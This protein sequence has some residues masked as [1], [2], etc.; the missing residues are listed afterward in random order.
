[1]KR[2][3]R[4][5]LVALMALPVVAWAQAPTAATPS[6][7]HS[8]L[9]VQRL[10]E[11][12][13]AALVL[14]GK[15]W[16]FLK[17]HHPAVTAGQRP[18]DD[19][20]LA[21]LPA[22]L[23]ARKPRD[24]Q[25]LLTQWIDALGPVE[26]CQ[27]C[28]GEGW[29]A[30]SV[31]SQPRTRWIADRRLL[32]QDLSARLVRIHHNRVKSQ[33][34][35]VQ[36]QPGVGNPVFVDEANYPDA[37]FPDSGWQILG[38][39]RFWNA[40]EYWYPYRDLIPEDWDAVL[41]DSPR[42]MALPLQPADWHREL[43]RLTARIRDGHA[44]ILGKVTPRQPFGLCRL[45]VSLRVVDGKYIVEAVLADDE[46]AHR[47]EPGDVLVS[48]D[49]RKVSDI[50][51]SV[52][53]T[54]GASNESFRAFAIGRMLTTGACGAARAGVLRDA[55][56][57]LDVQRVAPQ[58]MRMA[59]VVMNDR[60]GDT[61]QTLPGDVAY[62]KLSSIKLDDVPG[63]VERLAGAK[64]LVIDIR[65]YPSAFVVFA[66]GQAL[67]DEPTP[68][69]IF[70]MASLGNPG[71]FGFG[72]MLS[73]TPA[74]P[75]FGG[76]V[77]I[78][79]DESSISNAEYTAMALRASPRARLYGRQ[80]AGAD[81]NVSTIPLPGGLAA[82]MSGIGVFYPDRS[83]TQQ[84]GL[85]LDVECPVTVAGLRAGRDEILDCALQGLA[86]P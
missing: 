29:D 63:Y 76:R 53:D 40:V 35:Y 30:A 79:V 45:P 33:Q 60:E 15:V 32:G 51:A 50:V 26:D 55:P 59:P 39:L 1:M 11:R 57:D 70:S 62:L 36:L 74:Q 64:V 86:T 69:V 46:I 58:S 65:N 16:G 31:A 28:A 47:F 54:Y 56:L 75:H 25:A 73:L 42:R 13:L 52:R 9:N 67:V 2:R 41:A 48:L 38:V 49:D 10:D 19:E 43:Y 44:G 82:S 21:R 84:R 18:W 22:I 27:D 68:F 85:K 17:Y 80:T 12:Q 71:Q 72:S 3:M 8:S 24:V 78:L 5:G 34:H 81:G 66:L 23:A 6:I 7:T 61:F 83:P 37:V 14:T 4:L 20:L 77:A